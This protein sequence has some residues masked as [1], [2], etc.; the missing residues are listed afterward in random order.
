MEWRELHWL[1][2]HRIPSNILSTVLCPAFTAV[3]RSRF[4]I[5]FKRNNERTS[6]PISNYSIVSCVHWTAVDYFVSPLYLVN[7]ARFFLYKFRWGKIFGDQWS[8]VY[9]KW[10]IKFPCF[11]HQILQVKNLILSFSTHSKPCCLDSHLWLH[12]LLDNIYHDT[13]ECLAHVRWM[14]V[15]HAYNNMRLT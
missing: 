1:C 3:L 14:M 4:S 8:T 11:L 10:L 7:W 6:F 5:I 12:F 9:V 2:H 15:V 13:Q